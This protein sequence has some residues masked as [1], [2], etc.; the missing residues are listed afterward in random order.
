MKAAHGVIYFL[1]HFCSVPAHSHLR[2]HMT[3]SCK[4]NHSVSKISPSVFVSEIRISPELTGKAI[5]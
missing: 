2:A 1:S 3:V 4:I 5:S